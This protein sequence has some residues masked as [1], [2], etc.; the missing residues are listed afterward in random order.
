MSQKR[1]SN[2]NQNG[3]LIDQESEIVSENERVSLLES[4]QK[5]K[6][7]T[8]FRFVVGY[9]FK[10]SCTIK[11]KRFTFYYKFKLAELCIY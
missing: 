3:S 2:Q 11:Q 7:S 4:S 8:K 9:F 6:K 1:K 10:L 5:S